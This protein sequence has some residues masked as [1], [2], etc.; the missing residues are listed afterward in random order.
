MIKKLR[1]RFTALAM[2]SMFLVLAVLIGGINIINYRNV[3][4]EADTL[5]EE[6]AANNGAF[7]LRD[8]ANDPAFAPGGSIPMDPAFAPE[9]EEN[10]PMPER[11]PDPFG[12]EIFSSRYFSVLFEKDG[13]VKETDTFSIYMID[14][15][16]A[17]EMAS[18]VLNSG[19]TRGFYDVYRFLVTDETGLTRVIFYDC[20][21]N[22]SNFITFRNTSILISLIGMLLVFVMIYLLS[23]II[24][25]PASESYEKQKRFITDAGHE[26]KTPLAIISADTDVLESEV[27][28]DNEWTTDIKK[29]IKN[30]T[31]LTNDLVLLSKMEEGVETVAAEEIDLTGL[32]EDLSSSFRSRALTENK[33]L[34]CDIEKGL[35]IKSNKSGITNICSILL[36]NAIKYSPENGKIILRLKRKDKYA[37]MV[38]KNSTVTDL[39]NENIKHLFD[40]FYRTD[41]SRNSETGGHGLGL[42]IAKARTENLGGRIS[43]SREPG[44]LV[45]TVQLPLA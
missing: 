23:G 28:E 38:V 16:G 37:Q 19:K 41:E 33:V 34:E 6:L 2:L 5:L 44:F 20:G 14:D 40:R 21:R 18:R 7:P 17:E 8:S 39:T 11:R 4:S 9:G 31:D 12:E 10:F 32:I 15:S 42:S 29:Q 3:V 45:M 36:D 27:G 24:I 1:T 13:S 35:T 26:I 22:L 25:R 30:L 43:S